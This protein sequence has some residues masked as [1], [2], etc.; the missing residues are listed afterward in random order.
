MGVKK[1]FLSDAPS[2]IDLANLHLP[3]LLALLQ[4]FGG[5]LERPK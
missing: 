1:Y 3:P 2:Y 5:D 4:Q